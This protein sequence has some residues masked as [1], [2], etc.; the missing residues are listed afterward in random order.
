MT[1][2]TLP[3]FSFQMGTVGVGSGRPSRANL[4]VDQIGRND[5]SDR[6]MVALAR[7]AFDLALPT[8]DSGLDSSGRARS[9]RGLGT[10][11][12]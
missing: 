9:G 6:F 10:S 1:C 7:L 8:E 11:L 12:V 5:S 2:P 4:A 3:R